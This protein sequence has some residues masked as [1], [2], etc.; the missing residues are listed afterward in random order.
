[1]RLTQAVMTMYLVIRTGILFTNWLN[2][3]HTFTRSHSHTFAWFSCP[4]P[5]ARR[6]RP[7]S[8]APTSLGPVA[9]LPARLPSAP[10]ACRRPAALPPAAPVLPLLVDPFPLPLPFQLR[11][12]ALLPPR[13]R[14]SLL[15]PSFLMTPMADDAQKRGRGVKG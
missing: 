6:R 2:T 10:P 12:S 1:M 4:R 5:G 15:R 9:R 11:A 3:F 13:P 8:A 14:F 7:A